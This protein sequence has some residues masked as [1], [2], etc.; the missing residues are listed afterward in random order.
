[1]LLLDIGS[2]EG[3][4]RAE[5]GRAHAGLYFRS[6]WAEI[7]RDVFS[8]LIPAAHRQGLSV[9]ARVSLR[10]MNWVD[11]TLGWM[12][13]SYDPLRRQILLSPYLDLFHPGFQEYLVGLLTDLAG[14]G[15]D[16][17]LF[18]NDAPIGPKDGF[19]SYAMQGF[20]HTFKIRVDPSKLFDLAPP[21]NTA[22][23]REAH[24]P[25]RH[26]HTYPPEFWRWA[27][28][29]AREQ[30][31][32][33]DRLKRAMQIRAPALQFALEIHPEAITD[34][35]A[36]LIQYGEDVLEAKRVF[37]FILTK[38]VLSLT[39]HQAGAARTDETTELVNRM[40]EFIGEVARVWIERPIPGNNGDRPMERIRLAVDCEETPS[41]IGLIYM[42]N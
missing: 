19:T 30:I 32:I 42:G 41:G 38:A 21:G 10:R 40:K 15:I 36:A 11:P 17:V 37:T 18:Q 34:P 16:G 12:D 4:S 5:T 6:G 3:G 8:D 13:R 35:V 20:E 26:R 23:S 22:G 14:T 31:R 29:K 24:N 7:I 9:F 27:G 2:R 25:D 28:W 33:M 1:M 39:S